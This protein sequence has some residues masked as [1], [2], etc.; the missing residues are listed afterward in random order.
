MLFQNLFKRLENIK[1]T[2]TGQQ[3]AK[4][5]QNRNSFPYNNNN[6][7]QEVVNVWADSESESVSEEEIFNRFNLKSKENA[8]INNCNDVNIDHINNNNKDI[9]LKLDSNISTSTN[10]EVNKTIS[11]KKYEEENT[12]E[13]INYGDKRQRK[14]T[15]INNK[16]YNKNNMVSIANTNNIN[17]N[18][19]EDL[20]GPNIEDIQNIDSYYYNNR[21][22]GIEEKDINQRFEI[23]IDGHNKIKKR[24]KTFYEKAKDKALYTNEEKVALAKHNLKLQEI[25]EKKVVSELQQIAR[26]KKEMENENQ[27]NDENEEDDYNDGDEKNSEA[28]ANDDYENQDNNDYEYYNN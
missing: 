4:N 20:I 5:K 2:N 11:S 14:S 24:P 26:S 16:Y 15:A 12:Q 25:R 9:I 28:N 18:N 7:P 13:N 19:E 23:K 22:Y 17:I 27:F 6:K 8:A 21:S 10:N 1:D 3:E